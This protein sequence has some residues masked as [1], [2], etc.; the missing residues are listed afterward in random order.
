M[1]A[2]P[3]LTF[4]GVALVHWMHAGAQTGTILEAVFVAAGTAIAAALAVPRHM[5]AIGGAVLALATLASHYW[6][7]MPPQQ[8]APLLILIQTLFGMTVRH[9][10]TPVF[11]PAPGN[12]A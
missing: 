6:W 2:L 12:P 7:H 8:W 3:A 10:A 11:S 1:L 4:L 9:Q 5:T